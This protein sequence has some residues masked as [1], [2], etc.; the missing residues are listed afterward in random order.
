[1]SKLNLIDVILYS[2]NS[3]T[4]LDILSL[5]LLMGALFF[6][7]FVLYQYHNFILYL[8]LTLDV[9]V[10]NYLIYI[11][12][13]VSIKRANLF[14]YF[15]LIVANFIVDLIAYAIFILFLLTGNLYVSLA[16]ALIIF[17]FFIFVPVIITT[18]DKKLHKGFL[19]VIFSSIINSFN[20]YKKELI[21]TFSTVLII[22]LIFFAINLLIFSI[23]YVIGYL[24][25][26]ILYY[27]YA[28]DL[29][30][31]LLSSFFLSYLI[32]SEYRAAAYIYKL[33]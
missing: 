5:N 27:V 12:S 25:N 26:S 22:L 6:S 11:A 30:I 9:L 33:K 23:V 10:F 15:K 2:L 19:K 29:I 18:E 24:V 32:T 13:G 3:I 31:P 17:S 8:V 16:I 20:F 28:L 1:M 7:T 4:N 21:F 14:T